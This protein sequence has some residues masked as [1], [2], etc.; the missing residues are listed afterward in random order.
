MLEKRHRE[1]ASQI[2][3]R[4][5]DGR[6]HDITTDLKAPLG[7]DGTEVAETAVDDDIDLALTELKA[8]TLRNV[9]AALTRLDEGSYGYCSECEDEIPQARLKAMP[10]AIR[11]RECES[12][13]EEAARARSVGS[14]D[15]LL[16]ALS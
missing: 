4:I 5:R 9:G 6:A 15:R 7:S 16:R 3:G 1:L 10:F 11:C 8:E 14:R 13:R 2:K 12:T